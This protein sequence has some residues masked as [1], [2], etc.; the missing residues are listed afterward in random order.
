LIGRLQ[1]RGGFIVALIGCN[2]FPPLALSLALQSQQANPSLHATG[3]KEQEVA[4]R[5]AKK[6]LLY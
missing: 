4:L 2:L 1:S 3:E 5:I 6:K